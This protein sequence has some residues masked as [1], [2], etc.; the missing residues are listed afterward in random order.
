VE[1][2]SVAAHRHAIARTRVV[3]VGIASFHGLYFAHWPYQMAAAV[4]ALTSVLIVFLLAQRY[5]IRG[6]QITGSNIRW[7]KRDLS[8]LSSVILSE[9]HNGVVSCSTLLGGPPKMPV[10]HDGT[11]S[12]PPRPSQALLSALAGVA[13]PLR[14]QTR[15]S[16]KSSPPSPIS[17]VRCW[18]NRVRIVVRKGC[19][20]A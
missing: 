4:T 18:G 9:A 3:E 17:F 7:P 5:F 20:A 19:A 10:Q 14:I 8:G 2:L 16:R 15:R 1:E 6:I 13:A 12:S 11:I